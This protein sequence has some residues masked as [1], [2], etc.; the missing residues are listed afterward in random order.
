MT[1][2]EVNRWTE[3][4]ARILAECHNRKLNTPDLI[5]WRFAGELSNYAEYSDDVFL[6]LYQQQTGRSD[7]T[8]RR[9]TLCPAC[10][11][12]M[13]VGQSCGCFDNGGE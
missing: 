5:A 6:R 11:S 10:G 9:S 3:T 12:P 4:L 2:D 7:A 13:P 1:Q 8:W